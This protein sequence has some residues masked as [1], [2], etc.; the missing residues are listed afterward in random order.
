M[1]DFFDPLVSLFDTITCDSLPLLKS[2]VFESTPLVDHHQRAQQLYALFDALNTH[3]LN[4]NFN[5]SSSSCSSPTRAAS[6]LAFQHIHTLVG[7]APPGWKHEQL[8]IS[9]GGSFP[10]ELLLPAVQLIQA[11]DELHLVQLSTYIH[12]HQSSSIDDRLHT[13][14]FIARLFDLSSECLATLTQ[15]QLAYLSAATSTSST[16]TSASVLPCSVHQSPTITMQDLDSATATAI[17]QQSKQQV[18][19]EYHC[20]SPITCINHHH[21]HHHHVNEIDNDSFAMTGSATFNTN[22]IAASASASPISC[23]SECNNNN[24]NNNTCSAFFTDQSA[25]PA[26]HILSPCSAA[27]A[28]SISSP[29]CAFRVCDTDDQALLLRSSSSSITS[30]SSISSATSSCSSTTAATLDSTVQPASALLQP[31]PITESSAK[32]LFAGLT[33]S[34]ADL[35][36]RALFSASS[37]CTG[38]LRISTS[39]WNELFPPE[40]SAASASDL[41]TSN[42]TDT[43]TDNLNAP[44]RSCI[45]ITTAATAIGVDVACQEP[46]SRQISS[47]I[48]SRKR[49]AS[50]A[51]NLDEASDSELLDVLASPS[52]KK[53]RLL[54][55]IHNIHNI[56]THHHHHSATA[57]NSMQLFTCAPTPPTLTHA[58]T[59]RPLTL[60]LVQQAASTTVYRRFLRP[61]PKLVLSGTTSPESDDGKLWVEVSLVGR[62]SVVPFTGKC[63]G[64]VCMEKISPD[65]PACMD[66]IK[67]LFTTRQKDSVFRLRFE[68]KRHTSQ[69]FEVIPSA[70]VYSH[71]ITVYSHTDYIKRTGMVTLVLH[72]PTISPTNV[73]S[74][75]LPI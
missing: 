49:S 11:F 65:R 66:K 63:L 67:I 69:G 14:T 15:A 38:A 26:S 64:G 75:S 45:T 73:L 41:D 70:T 44:P 52:N 8:R 19:D 55:N 60:I 1:L 54:D 43:D 72:S 23:S 57:D 37:E 21:H 46:E 18:D 20:S 39:T 12:Q 35:D 68:L 33:D 32:T 58:P 42:D 2:S 7:L 13:A 17:V 31:M 36:I 3:V 5:T 22:S 56:H 47:S 28:A 62:D 4:L 61:I 48:A 9:T 71:P 34:T 25:L 27:A 29:S 51:L 24:N 74:L 10:S 59:S 53:P 6:P 30:D 16:S 50:I 40:P